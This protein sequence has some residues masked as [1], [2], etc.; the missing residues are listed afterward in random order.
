MILLSLMLR[1]KSASADPAV[2]DTLYTAANQKCE[3]IKGRS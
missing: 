1:R 3:P 2:L